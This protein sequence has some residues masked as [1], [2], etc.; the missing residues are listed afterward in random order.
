MKR[1]KNIKEVAFKDYTVTK[2]NLPF[3]IVFYPGF[4]GAFFGFSESNNSSVLFCSCAEEAIQNYIRFRLCTPIPANSDPTRCFIGCISFLLI[5][6]T[7]QSGSM[8][9]AETQFPSS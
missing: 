3:P 4:Y 6:L 8:K 2:E 7:C 9:V 5:D 1:R